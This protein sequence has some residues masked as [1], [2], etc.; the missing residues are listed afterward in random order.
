MNDLETKLQKLRAIYVDPDDHAFLDEIEKGL[1]RRIVESDLVSN[2][3]VRAIIEDGRKKIE[4][5]TFILANDRNISEQE[6]KL[7]FD[8]R[9]VHQFY[10]DRFGSGEKAKEAIEKT[11]AFVDNALMDGD[12]TAR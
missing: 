9:E 10:L 8:K 7:L 1:R 6:R 4:E 11:A 3:V 12:H 2:D 5:I